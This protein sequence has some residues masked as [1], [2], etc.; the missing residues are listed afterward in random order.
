MHFSEFVLSFEF[1]STAITDETLSF[2]SRS[3][4]LIVV[5][6][7]LYVLRGTQALLELKAG[8]DSMAQAGDLRVILVQY[9]PICRSSWAQELRRARVALTLI[10]WKGEKSA[11]LSSRFWKQLQVEL[12][13]RRIK[14]SVNSSELPLCSKHK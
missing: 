7:P 6:S 12:P 13:V 5:L 10:Q 4:R 11:D 14:D 8:L 3:R 9:Q 2:V 1:F